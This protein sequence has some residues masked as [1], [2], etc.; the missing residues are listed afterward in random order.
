MRAPVLISSEHFST[1]FDRSEVAEL[2]SDFAGYDLRA[3]AVVRDTYARFLSSYNTHVTAGGCLGLEDY[4]RTM[5]VPGTRFM[6]A[7]ETLRIWQDGFGADCVR[8]VD[9]DTD[10]DVT[11]A[12]LRQ[13]GI[14]SLP[15]GSSTFRDRTSLDPGTV[16]ALRSANQTIRERQTT[17]PE[18]SLAAWLQMSAFSILARRRL[19]SAA[20]D[21]QPMVWRVG[22][23]T[24][25]SLDA[26]AAD[27]RRFL[28]DT[29]GLSSGSSV[30]R[31]RIV[32]VDRPAADLAQ[33]ARGQHVAKEVMRGRWGA[34]ESLVGVSSRLAALR[35]RAASSPRR[36]T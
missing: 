26:I 34:S 21:R 33:A 14:E 4:A 36:Q 9:Y 6:S 5:L 22:S 18:A 10:P 11:P 25:A 3:V 15:L 29:F 28:A 12:L 27:D 30:G 24:L 32:V 8:V 31:A 19:G 17:A 13:C 2:A 1:H 7:A 35:R 16:E 23:Q 20:Q